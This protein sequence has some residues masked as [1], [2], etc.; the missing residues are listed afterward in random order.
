MNQST[1][2]QSPTR[3][4]GLD[5]LRALAI[6]WVMCFHSFLVGG[7]NPHF[8]WLSTYGWMGVDLF[9]VLSGFLIGGQVLMPLA[10]GRAFSFRD[11]YLRRAFRI[12]PAYWVVLACYLLIPGFREAP[13]MEEWWQFVTFTLNLLI[14]YPK[15]QAFSHAWSLCIEEHFY[16]VFPLLAVVL[17]PRLSV[18]RFVALLVACVL[19]GLVL[20]VGIWLYNASL[21]PERGWFI[22]KIYYPT[23]G[24]L[25]GLLVGVALAAWKIFRPE[26]WKRWGARS[27]L[28]M[29]AGLLVTVFSCWLCTDRPGLV[30][31]S[32][33]WP[34]L[35]AGFGLL[36]FAGAQPKGWLGR[37][38][39]PG[40]A[41]LA[42]ISYS[43]YLI[44]KPIY[45]LVAVNV[46]DALAGHGVAGFFC[47]GVASILGGAILYYAVERP[48]LRLR[49]RWFQRTA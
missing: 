5:L 36:V 34:V 46:G 17:V 32:V 19:A 28:F 45:H 29:M 33:G 26:S 31:N 11:F 18:R 15:N 14:E 38:E 9:F 24:R 12:L 20:R 40:V 2:V 44:H 3:L 37:R 42:A 39:L 16:L 10:R 4:P 41:W 48:G 23:W 8:S 30:S 13:R 49:A 7:V 27:N 21:T 6:V 47:Y 35:S 43:L 25:D 1:E 22:E